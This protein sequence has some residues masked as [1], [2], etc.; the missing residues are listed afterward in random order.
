MTQTLPARPL[1]LRSYS[2][3]AVFILVYLGVLFVVL[4]PREMIAAQPGNIL[5][6]AD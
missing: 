3:L 2:A 5:R 1:P 6:E 4:A